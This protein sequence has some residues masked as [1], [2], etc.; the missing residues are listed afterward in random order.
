MRDPDKNTVPYELY[1]ATKEKNR[2]L[3]D[4]NTKL[5]IQISHL[6][7]ELAKAKEVKFDAY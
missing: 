4:E 5:K 7:V 2:E 3:L 6:Q 1:K